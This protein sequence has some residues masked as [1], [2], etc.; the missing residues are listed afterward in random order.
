MRHNNVT[1]AL[2][3]SDLDE[4]QMFRAVGQNQNILQTV[5]IATKH[6]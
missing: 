2:F 6:T 5:F 4:W 1:L 3:N